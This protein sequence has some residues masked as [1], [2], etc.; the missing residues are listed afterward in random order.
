MRVHR[1]NASANFFSSIALTPIIQTCV[2]KISR[3]DKMNDR[4]ISKTPDA[5]T[6]INKRLR[7]LL[8]KLCFRFEEQFDFVDLVFVYGTPFFFDQAASIVSSILERKATT[9][10]IITG[11]I[12]PHGEPFVT[13]K[14]E[15][16]LIYEKITG[17]YENVTF[18]LEEQS[19]NTLENAIGGLKVLNFRHY[20]TM[21]FV[22]PSHGAMRGYLTLKKFLPRTRLL[23]RT[24]DAQYPGESQ[25][26]SKDDWH[27]SEC[28]RKRVWGEYLRIKQYGQRGDIEYKEVKCLVEEIDEYIT[29]KLAC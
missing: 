29:S 18:Y 26:V 16:R 3:R 2:K 9:K 5:P 24:Y 13:Q 19:K 4:L 10:V 1:A 7:L 28:G 17:L 25:Q 27:N 14:S 15:A 8:T 22:F 21:C 12:V 11:G 23:Q 6:H 20:A